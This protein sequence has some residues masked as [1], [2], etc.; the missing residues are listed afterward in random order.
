MKE[1]PLFPKRTFDTQTVYKN[2]SVTL[3]DKRRH[4]IGNIRGDGRFVMFR[5][6]L[7]IPVQDVVA[8][9]EIAVNMYTK[10]CEKFD[11]ADRTD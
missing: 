4:V 3:M 10:E 5:K 6:D 8:I 2:G 9:A 7:I 11:V 1:K